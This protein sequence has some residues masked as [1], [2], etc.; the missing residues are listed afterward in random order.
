MLYCCLCYWRQ[1]IISEYDMWSNLWQQLELFWWLA[2][3][4]FCRWGLTNMSEW[5]IYPAL[6]AKLASITTRYDGKNCTCKPIII[7]CNTHV[8]RNNRMIRAFFILDIRLFGHVHNLL[9][10]CRHTHR[11]K[12]SSME[13]KFAL[14]QYLRRTWI[15]SSLLDDLAKTYIPPWKLSLIMLALS[16]LNLPTMW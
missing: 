7:A 16:S 8:Y 15:C 3:P 5:S 12:W 2:W 14:S 6:W 4:P 10:Q 13:R 11:G 1:N 9:E